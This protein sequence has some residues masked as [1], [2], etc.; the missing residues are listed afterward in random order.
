M[1]TYSLL[2]IALRPTKDTPEDRLKLATNCLSE[3]LPK[4]E[5]QP[6]IPIRQFTDQH[7]FT[8]AMIV[9]ISANNDPLMNRVEQL[10]S[11]KKNQV[12]MS[13]FTIESAFYSRYLVK[14]IHRTADIAEIEKLYMELVPRVVGVTS[15]LLALMTRKLKVI[16]R[17]CLS[18]NFYFL[19]HQELGFD[20][21][22][23]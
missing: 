18:N 21:T 8:S 4:L 5:A 19:G 23:D 10:Y 3:I 9:A 11:S 15:E 14:K 13:A 17:L 20:K 2:L 6:S 22:C 1:T 12:K 7:F 16:A